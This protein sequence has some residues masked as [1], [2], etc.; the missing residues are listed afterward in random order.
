MQG[1]APEIVF[2]ESGVTATMKLDNGYIYPDKLKLGYT[3]AY[4]NS[5]EYT[6][7]TFDSAN[8]LYIAKTNSSGSGVTGW[9]HCRIVNGIIC[10]V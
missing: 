1:T 6:G 4:Y 3:K 8:D 5:I 7:T 9:L 10:S 2:N